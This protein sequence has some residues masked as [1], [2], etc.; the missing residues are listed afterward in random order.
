MSLSSLVKDTLQSTQKIKAKTPDKLRPHYANVKTFYGD[1]EGAPPQ[2]PSQTQPYDIEPNTRISVRHL[3]FG[4]FRT[5]SFRMMIYWPTQM[6]ENT[7]VQIKA[8]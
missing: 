7:H 8:E 1:S 4:A 5:Q 2:P 3:K 6:S